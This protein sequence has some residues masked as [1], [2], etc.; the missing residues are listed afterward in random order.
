MGMKGPS[1]RVMVLVVVIVTVFVVSVLM[2]L[3]SPSLIDLFRDDPPP[4]GAQFDLSGIRF[5]ADRQLVLSDDGS[6]FNSTVREEF[7]QSKLLL[8]V[9]IENTSVRWV[10]RYTY[11]Y[12]NGLDYI[13]KEKDNSTYMLFEDWEYDIVYT[14]SIR[15]VC[16]AGSKA[17]SSHPLFDERSYCGGSF[18]ARDRRSDRVEFFDVDGLFSETSREISVAYYGDPEGHGSMS[19]YNLMIRIDAVGIGA[20]D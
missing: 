5:Y 7:N 6:G 15:F 18:V 13:E 1:Q 11:K 10:Q 14:Y 2:V 9:E 4:S 12:Y 19:D 16:V 3:T 8:V 17:V 20:I